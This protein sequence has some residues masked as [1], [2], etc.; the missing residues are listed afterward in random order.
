VDLGAA[1]R[2]AATASSAIPMV[3]AAAPLSNRSARSLMS[4]RADPVKSKSREELVIR[5]D[6]REKRVIRVDAQLGHVPAGCL[7]G[8]FHLRVSDPYDLL[9]RCGGDRFPIHDQ[10]FL[11][12]EFIED[13][14]TRYRQA[15]A[16]NQDANAIP[17]SDRGSAAAEQESRGYEMD[18][19]RARAAI[20]VD[21]R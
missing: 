21:H 11:M 1:H 2:L 18:I 15:K 4:R 19:T 3:C 6:G 14:L 10:G 16:A 7:E 5:E 17:R 9:V 8:L 12:R 13:G 20:A